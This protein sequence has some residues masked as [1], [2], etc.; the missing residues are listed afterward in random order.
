MF[1]FDKLFIFGNK[2]HACNKGCKAQEQFVTSNNIPN[3]QCLPFLLI[4]SKLS[5]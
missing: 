1:T 5:H 4:V 2:M 3:L